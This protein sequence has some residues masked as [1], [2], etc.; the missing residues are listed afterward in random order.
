ME[1]S[2]DRLTSEQPNLIAL[3]VFWEYAKQGKSYNDCLSAYEAVV[4][5]SK[6]TEVI[7]MKEGDTITFD[8]ISGQRLDKPNPTKTS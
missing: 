8:G 7:G 5:S 1:S 4:N 6:H 2:P 3:G